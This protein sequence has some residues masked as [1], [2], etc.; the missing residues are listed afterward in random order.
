MWQL[1]DG[2]SSSSDSS[3]YVIV[4]S[5]TTADLSSALALIYAALD[6]G[7][8]YALILADGFD[9]PLTLFSASIVPQ[10]PSNAPIQSPL[11][12]Q[13]T[14]LPTTTAKSTWKVSVLGAMLGGAGLLSILFYG[15]SYFLSFT[16]P[17]GQ[18]ASYHSMFILPVTLFFYPSAKNEL[19]DVYLSYDA[20]SS[21]R[22]AKINTFLQKG[23]LKTFFNEYTRGQ[24]V[25]DPILRSRVF[26]AFVTKS[27]MNS[28]SGNGPK[29]E[30]DGLYKAF[31]NAEN[32]LSST[33]MLTVVLEE[34]LDLSRSTER[35]L[36]LLNQGK[37]FGNILDN[38]KEWQKLLE[39]IKRRTG[40]AR[41]NN[42]DVALSVDNV[43]GDNSLDESGVDASVSASAGGAATAYTDG[44]IITVNN[45]SG[46][47]GANSNDLRYP[48]KDRLTRQNQ[49]LAHTASARFGS[50]LRLGQHRGIGLARI[51]ISG[52]EDIMVTGN[53]P[54]QSGKSTGT[55]D[56][57]IMGST[58]SLMQ[59]VG[60]ESERQ[61]AQTTQSHQL[62][63]VTESHQLPP[64]IFSPRPSPPKINTP[65]LSAANPHLMEWIAQAREWKE[66]HGE[67]AGAPFYY[68]ETTFEYQWDTPSQGYTREDTRLVL[69]DGTVIDDPTTVT[70]LEVSTT[71]VVSSDQ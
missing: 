20:D 28:V 1:Q 60:G 65:P 41:N 23:G 19:Y 14:L 21:E 45:C 9:I 34:G 43:K 51:H 46:G 58:N 2:T 37:H 42:G 55:I 57:S 68:K 26:V 4:I 33:N 10:A 5:I 66:L 40:T 22:V 49:V 62:Q 27:Y 13:P 7:A 59:L 25:V 31:V 8:L 70:T 56:D 32:K 11:T 47:G 50:R 48:V 3:N 35:S 24:D 64:S 63:P 30:D 15:L 67:D 17:N 44:S 38:P 69:L 36:G 71:V 18:K 54:G 12:S 29:G 16:L 6:S 53:A 52:D 39:E 61:P